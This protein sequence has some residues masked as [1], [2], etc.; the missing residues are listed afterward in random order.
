MDVEPVR[1]TVEFMTFA[2]ICTGIGG[3]DLAFERA[4]FTLLWM[5]EKDR[6]CRDVLRKHWPDK[7]IYEDMLT[8]DTGTVGRPDVLCGG[9]PCQGFS[10]AGLGKSLGDE[11]SNLCRRFVQICDEL[12]PGLVLWENVPGVLS[13]SDNAFGCFLGA[14]VGM[15]APLVPPDYVNRWEHGKKGRYFRWTSAG[16][17]VGSKRTACWRVLDSQYF[18][19]AQRRE[20]V[21]VVCDLGDGRAEKILFERPRV[22]W[23]P[24][25]RG[26]AG[27]GITGS[28]SARTDGGGGL[29]TDFDCGGACPGHSEVKPTPAIGTTPKPTSL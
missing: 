16:M 26:E 1:D 10:V 27:E 13:Q 25:A 7:P 6:Q 28:L 29:G 9:T 20:R 17:V 4:G 2:S 15:S 5:C 18:G 8:L 14:L 12:N 19:V 22:L 3:F 21:F 24:P 23:H 11:R